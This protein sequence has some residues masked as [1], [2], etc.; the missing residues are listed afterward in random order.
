[1]KSQKVKEFIDELMDHIRISM[2][3]E[4]DRQLAKVEIGDHAKEQLRLAMT[5]A[6]ELAEQEM[7]EKLTR[8][9]D[10]KEVLPKNGECVLIKVVDQ[11]D[12]EA[13]YMGSWEG[14]RYITDFGLVFGNDFDDESVPDMNIKAI[15]WREIM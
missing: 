8:W 2:F 13:L 3:D 1:M 6:V 14:D 11:L 10:P 7:A 4:H 12:N 5:H 9:N 15:G